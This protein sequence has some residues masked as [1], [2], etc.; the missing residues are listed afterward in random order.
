MQEVNLGFNLHLRT[1]FILI[2]TSVIRRVV[3]GSLIFYREMRFLSW[4]SSVRQKSHF[5][6]SY[7]NKQKDA[8]QTLAVQHESDFC[9]K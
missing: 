9:E 2:V 5:L 4:L 3:E 8:T 6:V 1:L 7:T